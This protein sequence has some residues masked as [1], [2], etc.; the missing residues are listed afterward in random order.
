MRLRPLFCLAALSLITRAQAQSP[1]PSTPVGTVLSAWLDAYHSGDSARMV[2]FNRQYAP[3]V[4]PTAG[5]PMRRSL[6]DVE[7]VKILKEQPQRLDFLVRQKSNG[8]YLRGT[9]EIAGDP[10][11][12]RTLGLRMVPPGAPPEGCTTYADPAPRATSAPGGV[13]PAD[14]ASEDAIVAALYASISGAACQHRDWDRFR[15]LFVAGGRLIPTRRT[16]DGKVSTLVESPD[17][18]VAGVRNGMEENGFFEHE[19]ARNG[20]TFGPITEI[21]STYESRR[22]ANDAKPFARGINSIQL[23]NDGTRWWVVTVYWQA[24][25]PDLPIPEAY[26]R[27][28]GR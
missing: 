25:R 1:I 7:F 10:P 23:L 17:E 11:V 2:A 18:Y 19:T 12:A 21:F 3:T 22:Q 16:S 27:S 24:E 6:G 8:N 28:G 4:P 9:I 20:H 15:S 5:V 14:V 13:D 26:L